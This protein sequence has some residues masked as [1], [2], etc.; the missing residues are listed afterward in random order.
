MT[1]KWSVVRAAGDRA[2]PAFQTA[3]N[4]LCETYWHPAYAFVRRSGYDA[5]DARDLTQA[6]FARVLEKELLKHAREDRGR[7][8]SFLL[9]S[10]RNFLSNEYDR[11]TAKKRGGCHTHVPLEFDAEERRYQLEPT[12]H[13]TPEAVYER[14]WAIGVL[15]KAMQRVAQLHEHS[16]R[17]SHFERL[18]QYMT[19]ESDVPTKKLVSELGMSDG[20]LRVA[21]SRLRKQYKD[22]LRETI[23]ETVESAEEIEDE[24]RHLM[25]VISKVGH[26]PFE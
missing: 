17:R 25:D 4:T 7:F 2:S 6:F 10:L 20:A 8:R 24:F 23:A 9:A 22:A 21:L 18:R 5:D 3:L 14:R 12:D 15:Q 26:R 1:T 13:L 19:D 11:R 16:P